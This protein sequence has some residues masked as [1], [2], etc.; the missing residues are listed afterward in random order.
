MPKKALML[1]LVH[2]YTRN[3]HPCNG[4]L[5]QRA[6]TCSWSSSPRWRHG[7]IRWQLAIHT[8]VISPQKWSRNNGTAARQRLYFSQLCDFNITF[9]C[10]ATILTLVT[11][12]CNL[13]LLPCL[14]VCHRSVA[15]QNLANF[16]HIYQIHAIINLFS[17]TR[18]N[19]CSDRDYTTG[20]AWTPQLA[21]RVTSDSWCCCTCASASCKFNTFMFLHILLQ[22]CVIKWS[23]TAIST[24]AI[25]KWN[26]TGTSVLHQQLNIQS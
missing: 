14:L 24:L 3:I 20:R 7:G 2:K 4:L 5:R 12:D 10:S 11:V 16:D 6:F 17:A 15:V 18:Y 19:N 8:P 26:C 21:P 23:N 1:I 9:D 22:P 25:Q 13:P